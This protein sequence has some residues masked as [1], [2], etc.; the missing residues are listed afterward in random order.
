MDQGRAVVMK[1]Y[2]CDGCQ[3]ISTEETYGTE[4]HAPPEQEE[5]VVDSENATVGESRS[6]T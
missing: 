1:N 6:Q 5:A 2:K 4:G 3:H